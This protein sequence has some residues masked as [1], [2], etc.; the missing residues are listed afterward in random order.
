[1]GETKIPYCTK[2]WQVTD[3]CSP[4]SPGCSYCYAKRIAPRL[5]VD[6]SKVTLHP[7]RLEEPLHWRKPQRVFVCSRSDLFH[8]EVSSE[9]IGRVWS[10]MLS[11]PRH[12]FLILT[13]RPE[14]MRDYVLCAEHEIAD[15]GLRKANN[16]H[17]G[18]SCENQEQADKRIP[19]L[20]Q[21]PAAVRWV[22]IEPMLGPVDIAAWLPHEYSEPL[23]GGDPCRVCGVFTNSL[24]HPY[25][26]SP[27][28]WVIVAGESGGPMNRAL[29]A[30][31]ER[32]GPYRPIA[33]RS[34]WVRS[35]RDQCRE[36]D[37]PFFFKGWGGPRPTSGGDLLDGKT[38]HELPE[39][40]R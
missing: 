25:G 30:L 12:T 32:G 13:K 18:V 20:L 39:V 3:G 10:K 26:K 36:Y 17:L 7:E 24:H 34:D 27:L 21:V 31:L 23:P 2:T 14:R 6:F 11:L 16:V 35:I 22:S 1:M 33:G 38:Y 5:G 19:I 4:V 28:D 15:K 9:F 8:P 29:C 40:T 37:V